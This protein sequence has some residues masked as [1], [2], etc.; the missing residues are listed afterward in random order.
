[1]VF[2]VWGCNRVY[3]CVE[4]FMSSCGSG[5]RIIIETNIFG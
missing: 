1:M 4:V 3:A 2:D 5:Y